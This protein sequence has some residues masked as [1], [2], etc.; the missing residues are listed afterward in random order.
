MKNANKLS[1]KIPAV[2]CL[3]MLLGLSAEAG[4]AVTDLSNVPLESSSSS[5]VRPNILFT[6]DDSG[7][8]AWAYLPDYAGGTTYT[9][10]TANHCKVSNTCGA[11]E[12]PFNANAYNGMAYNP[13][14]SYQLPVNADGTT[15]PSQG[16]P[17]TAVKIDGYGVQSAGT[18]NLTNGYPEVNY[19]NATTGL[20]KRN[21]IDTNNPFSYRA[22]VNG[23]TAGAIP[24]PDTNDD[25][26]LYAFP[27][28]I[29]TGGDITSTLFDS[30]VSG[31]LNQGVATTSTVFNGTLDVTTAANPITLFGVSVSHS[32]TTV[33]VDYTATTP[34]LVTGDTVVVSGSTCSSGYKSGGSARP[35]TVVSATRFTYVSN[36]GSSWGST[37]CSAVVTKPGHTAA[38]PKI[39]KAGSTVTVTLAAAP[40]PALVNGAAVTVVNGAGTCDAGYQTAAATMTVVN[41]TTFTYIVATGVAT[42]TNAKCNITMTVGSTPASPGVRLSGTTVTVYKT[43]HGLVTGDSIAVGSYSIKRVGG[44]VTVTLGTPTAPPVGASIWVWDGMGAGAC[45]AGYQAA[46][47]PG[48][49]GDVTD[50]GTAHT[51]TFTP[52]SGAPLGDASN[53]SCTLYSWTAGGGWMPLSAPWIPDS[54]DIGYQTSGTSV[55]R[56]DAN[57]FTYISA[58]GASANSQCVISKLGAVTTRAYTTASTRNGAPYYFTILPTEYCDSLYLTNCVAAAAPAGL[59]TYPAPVRFCKDDATALLPPGDAGAQ[60]AAGAAINCQAKYSVGPN[61]RSVRYGLFWRG[62]IVPTRATYGNEF[63]PNGTHINTN[64]YAGGGTDLDYSNIAAV[65][66]SRRADCAAVPNCTYAEEMTNFANWYAYYHT[67]MQMMKSAA[68][69]AFLS[70]DSRYRVG[71]ATINESAAKYLPVAQFTAAQKTNWYSKFYAVNPGSSTPLREALAHAGRYFAGK[72]PGVLTGDPMEYACQQNFDLI[73]TD[74]YWNGTDSDVKEMDGATT[75]RNYDK[76]NSGFSKRSDGAYDG[77]VAGAT[78]TLADVAMYYYKTDLRNSTLSN[79]T[80]ALGTDVCQDIVPMT[81]KD[82]A[83]GLTGTQHMKVFALG[84]ADGLMTYQKDYE[85]SASGDF[86]KIVTAAINCSFSGAGTCNWPL[87]VHDAQSALDDLWHAAVNARG[88]YFNAR[89]PQQLSDG[90]L[91][92]LAGINVRLAAASAAATSSPVITQHDNSIFSSIYRTTKWD[93]DVLARLVDP[94]TG[95]V[96]PAII[97]SAQGQLDAKVAA[98]ASAPIADR[99]IYALDPATVGVGP[100]L[101]DFMYANMN[102][103]EK[104]Y[105]DNKCSFV[106]LTQCSVATLTAGEIALGNDGSNL[107]NWLR[108]NKSLE[109]APVTSDAVYRAREHILGDTVNAKPAYVKLPQFSFKDAVVPSYDEFKTAQ[110]ALNPLAVP[111]GRQGVLYMGSNDGMLHA[112]NSD[113]GDELWAYVP[114]IVMPNLYKLAETSYASLHQYYVDGSPEVMDIYVD[115][116]SA[117]TSGM[118]V[119]WHTILVGGLGLGGRGFYALDITDPANPQGMWETCSDSTLCPTYSGVVHSDPDI[120]YSYGNPVITKRS[121]DGKWV[122]IVASGYNN[123]APG[124]GEGILFVLDVMTGEVLSKT[125]TGAATNPPSGLAKIRP[126]IDDIFS[127][128]VIDHT[129]RY[130]YGGDLNGDVWRFDLG[131]VASAGVP[132]VTRIASLKDSLGIAQSVTTRPAW[133]DSLKNIKNAMIGAGNPVISIA[134]GRYLGASDVSNLQVQSLYVLKDDLSHTGAAAYFGN[135]RLLSLA[136]ATTNTSAKPVM[137]Q[138]LH[139]SSGTTGSSST[140]TLDWTINHAGWFADFVITD[141]ANNPIVPSEHPGERVNLDPVQVANSLIVVANTPQSSACTIGGFSWVYTFNTLTGGAESTFLANELAVGFDIVLVQG[142]TPAAGGAA[143]SGGVKMLWTGSG[144]G[145]PGTFEPPIEGG[146]TRRASWRE[147]P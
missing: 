89:D 80:G 118:T 71:F 20:Y 50:G 26:N 45:D 68:G 139:Q 95:N 116:A 53:S 110:A 23:T 75:M 59:F 55:T 121:T 3:L 144:G 93:G 119:G 133:V 77:G 46:G 63:V 96:I 82:T 134:T 39:S 4:A 27:G 101:R 112:F 30:G 109:V 40:V 49:V 111:T 9:G 44:T 137:Q 105:F 7:S 25:P 66:R 64:G 51:F 5:A 84:L 114:K 43:A 19:Y 33:T 21:G 67:R 70:L 132:T 15:K 36:S 147:L 126:L 128:N 146:A 136:G 74:G 2:F 12:T 31:P 10:G 13:S 57:T 22:T 88:T 108:G 42:P 102:V 1:R 99:H 124:S 92:A 120:G 81:A 142:G 48:F 104:S 73:T 58:G 138:F 72:Q 115:A 117:V 29:K 60:S 83:A 123:V 52:L 76:D 38:N 78:D 56:V 16:S 130:I 135:P 145:T 113:T 47:N 28:S 61:F 79:C 17:W 6:L 18:I 127:A 122:V 140:Q 131:P 87:P 91:S 69:Q 125:S 54:C 62:D 8:M 86:R 106:L 90:L 37:S 85:S 24:S 107:I 100:G 65:D 103:T 98:D 97:W 35:I 11:G 141:S 41:T 14:T 129:V 143:V 94:A 34:A 32:G